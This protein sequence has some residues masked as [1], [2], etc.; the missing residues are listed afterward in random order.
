[1]FEGIDVLLGDKT[2][3]PMLGS[4]EFVKLCCAVKG[5]AVSVCV[6]YGRVPYPVKENQ[7]FSRGKAPIHPLRDY[8]CGTVVIQ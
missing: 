6:E 1:M 3:N 8:L 2:E 7:F 4:Q 5:P